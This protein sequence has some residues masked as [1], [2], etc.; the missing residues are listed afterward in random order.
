MKYNLSYTTVNLFG[1]RYQ[2]MRVLLYLCIASLVY[3]KEV[4][5]TLQRPQPLDDGC[6]NS[7]RAPPGYCILP[8]SILANCSTYEGVSTTSCY[9]EPY[10]R[11]DT[12]DG[13]ICNGIC[14]ST[15]NYRSDCTE[16]DCT[17]YS[18]DSV[19]YTSPSVV[20][21]S[22]SETPEVWKFNV[23]LGWTNDS[24]V[25]IPIMISTPGAEFY[26]GASLILLDSVNGIPVCDPPVISHLWTINTR[27]HYVISVNTSGT[28]GFTLEYFYANFSVTIGPITGMGCPTAL[29][30]LCVS[31]VTSAL[32]DPIETV[33]N[34]NYSLLT[35]NWTNLTDIKGFHMV[36][37]D[38]HAGL[39]SINGMP[40]TTLVHGSFTIKSTTLD[41][42]TLLL[43]LSNDFG[44]PITWKAATVRGENCSFPPP[45]IV[46]ETPACES[47]VYS[48]ALEFSVPDM[49]RFTTSNDTS[50][51]SCTNVT[52]Y[53]RP[54][55]LFALDGTYQNPVTLSYTNAYFKISETLASNN[56]TSVL[57]ND[58]LFDPVS[59]TVCLALANLTPLNLEQ[60]ELHTI[61]I[62]GGYCTLIASLESISPCDMATTY[63]YGPELLDVWVIS[64]V[65]QVVD[66]P[67]ARV[68]NSLTNIRFQAN[69]VRG[70]VCDGFA[71]TIFNAEILYR[72][73]TTQCP[74]AAPDPTS[75]ISTTLP[76]VTLNNPVVYRGNY[77]TN[78]FQDVYS[79]SFS[80]PWGNTV[81][82]G[83]GV[84]VGC[85]PIGTSPHM[86][87]N[88][89]AAVACID[90][91]TA[92]DQFSAI[93]A[94]D[95]HVSTNNLVSK[96]TSYTQLVNMRVSYEITAEV[97]SGWY[98]IG[99]FYMDAT[100]TGI[101][102]LK[103]PKFWLQTVAECQQK[104]SATDCSVLGYHGQEFNYFLTTY[105]LESLPELITTAA[106]CHRNYMM[107]P[108]QT[109]IPRLES[110]MTIQPHVHFVT[111]NT[112]LATLA[113]ELGADP[114]LMT[115]I[116]QKLGLG[117]KS[118]N[119]GDRVA[120][121]P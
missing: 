67:T 68:N 107:D 56:M 33:T 64:E 50:E 106:N 115:I 75:G 77:D 30:D 52:F 21:L 66:I 57:S 105:P 112:T 4:G 89:P 7:T 92:N 58:T 32:E 3:G 24:L 117:Y 19:V 39:V 29:D 45:V 93:D 42:T 55:W 88:R 61:T 54:E 84:M 99:A 104:Y 114:I 14:K 12:C 43:L 23:T 98:S 109:Y 69:T 47:T 62:T 83:T 10:V 6:I 81:K 48:E 25:R 72:P 103:L 36:A 46:L 59:T 100:N 102:T 26:R 9:T 78:Y 87:V 111:S 82:F 74:C 22:S 28:L 17:Y 53:P 8:P 40:V 91:D 101:D 108:T 20:S 80:L 70:L 51:L 35:F 121:P 94:A 11:P 38:T 18:Q 1:E 76:S 13:I 5:F 27:T 90:R 96:S 34:G 113:S 118:L 73:C 44:R 95:W 119:V 31:C 2:R 15:L 97:S 41:P 16:S 71:V 86:D 120:V 49:V 110:S 65:F 60:S 116:N 79:V 37:N 85:A 63:D